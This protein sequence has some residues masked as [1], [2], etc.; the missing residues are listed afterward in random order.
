MTKMQLPRI[1]PIL[2]PARLS[3]G[4]IGIGTLYGVGSEVQDDQEG[5]IWRL[6]GL[7]NGTHSADTIVSQMR[8]AVPEL[9]EQSVYEAIDTLISQGF[10][11]D[12]ATLP[13]SELSDTELERY[14]RNINYF[15]RVDT[16]PR[17]SPYEHQRRLKNA[18]VT[19]LGLGG[20]GSAMA[21]SL[22]AVGVGLLHLADFDQVEVSNLNRQLLY[23]ADDVGRPKVAAAID[24]LHQLNPYI[25]ITGQG[26]Q[27]NSSDD[28]VP[29]MEG[30]DL[31]ILC[32]DTP[33]VQL[34]L[35]VNDAALRTQTPWLINS[36]SGPVL[37]VGIFVPFKTPCYQCLKH[38]EDRQ[39]TEQDENILEQL[40]DPQMV[41]AVIAPTAS[42]TGHLGALEAIYFIT[43]LPAQTVGRVFH[44]DLTTYEHCFYTEVPFWPECPSCGANTPFQPAAGRPSLLVN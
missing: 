37:G 11:E 17:P 39:R 2:T 26:L 44:Q 15:S 16:Q 32:A 43:G 27:V 20:S 33:P 8:Q 22:A 12:A 31:F 42:L 6:F 34:Q 28:L 10:V 38:E 5:N 35:W 18:Q 13:P 41:Q 25:T 24:R 19:V 14:S 9:D 7:M 23:T 40:F 30:R 29:L 21:M 3:A 36:Y 1:K 4:R